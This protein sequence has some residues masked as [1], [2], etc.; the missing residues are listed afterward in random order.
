M[1]IV[2]MLEKS[3]LTSFVV[4]TGIGDVCAKDYSVE[5]MR[6]LLIAVMNFQLFADLGD[7]STQ[8]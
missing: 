6:G 1:N 4:S 3:I 7:H 5:E 2:I 8:E